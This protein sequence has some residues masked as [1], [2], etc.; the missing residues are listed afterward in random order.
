VREGV[1]SPYPLFKHVGD[2]LHILGM[3]DLE[4]WAHLKRMTEEP[5]ALL[6]L[7]GVQAF[8]DFQQQHGEFRHSTLSLTDLGVQVLNGEADWRL[9][10]TDKLWIGGLQIGEGNDKPWRWDTVNE[11]VV[12]L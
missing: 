11:N 5:H 12:I 8:P 1:N 9:L 2:Q 4:Y 6:Q 7:S 10:R 3:G